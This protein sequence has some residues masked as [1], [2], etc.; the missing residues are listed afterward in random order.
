MLQD[1]QELSSAA[2]APHARRSLQRAL[3]VPSDP[4]TLVGAKGDEAMMLAAID[5]LSSREPIVQVGVLTA[6]LRASEAARSLGFTPLQIWNGPLSLVH[7]AV[8]GFGPDVVLVVGADVLDGSYNP[9]LAMQMLAVADLAVRRGVLGS[10]LGFSLA[11]HPSQY[12]AAVFDGLAPRLSINVR[13][14]ISMSRF[15]RLS[16]ANATLVADVAFLLKPDITSTRVSTIRDWASE[17]RA[18]GDAVIGL[19][20]HPMLMHIHSSAGIDTLVASA[21]K[22]LAKLMHREGL[23]VVLLSH[24]YRGDMGD[25]ICLEP[26]FRELQRD[27]G[28]KILYPIERLGAAELKGVAGSLDGIL[29]G[30]MHL[31]IASLG[32]GVPV[33]ALTYQNK[34]EGL[35]RHFNLPDRFLL[36]PA[37][38]AKPERLSELIGSFV[39]ALSELRATVRRRLES[40]RQ[41]AEQNLQSLLVD[42]FG[43]GSR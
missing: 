43:H 14:E 13:D 33:A 24:D 9:I 31:A 19:N 41:A 16:K 5:Q 32:M 28:N 11:E 18:Q 39:N 21:K 15:R 1:W 23:S 38:A 42:A 12:V 40:V 36:D 4:F 6:T 7:S 3:I 26:I 29:T 34:F 17:R 20:M 37:D 25:D 30:R 35:F 8:S 2:V 10:I 27:F 22:A